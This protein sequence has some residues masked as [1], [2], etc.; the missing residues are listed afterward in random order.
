MTDD[1]PAKA[2]SGDSA[3]PTLRTEKRLRAGRRGG[4]RAGNTRGKGAVI[5]QIPWSIPVNLDKPTEPM[6]QEGVEAIHNNAM[7]ILEEVGVEFLNKE[8]VDIFRKEGCIIEN[9][10]ANGALVR[11]DR[12]WVMEKIALAPARWV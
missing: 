3:A 12:A 6:P 5:Q 9:E 10:N 11:M 2:A 4:G 8:A 1:N 7:R